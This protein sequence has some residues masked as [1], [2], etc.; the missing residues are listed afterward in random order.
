[1]DEVSLK[2]QPEVSGKVHNCLVILHI[3]SL[4]SSIVFARNLIISHGK[5][6]VIINLQDDVAT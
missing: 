2:T 4:K 1:M 3:Y 5:S 6:R